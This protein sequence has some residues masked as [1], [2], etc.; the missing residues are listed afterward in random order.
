MAY[1]EMCDHKTIVSQTCLV[2]PP[3]R[4]RFVLLKF[5]E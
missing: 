1:D 3:L 2:V 4:L 5:G